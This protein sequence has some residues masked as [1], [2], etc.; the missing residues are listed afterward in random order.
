[1]PGNTNLVCRVVRSAQL[2]VKTTV[3]IMLHFT[4]Q[5]G[6][7]NKKQVM[8]SIKMLA[9]GDAERG[10]TVVYLNQLI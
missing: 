2:T 5:E 4:P 6:E 8:H 10:F 7:I 1:M 3:Q 9:A